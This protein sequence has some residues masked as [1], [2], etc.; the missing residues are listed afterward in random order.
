MILPFILLEND[1]SREVEN[2]FHDDFFLLT[3]S[4]LAS[5]MVCIQSV[6]SPSSYVVLPWYSLAVMCRKNVTITTKKPY[7]SI[8]TKRGQQEGGKLDMRHES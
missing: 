4:V 3:L 7:I 5:S 2:L 8:E 6:S 1:E